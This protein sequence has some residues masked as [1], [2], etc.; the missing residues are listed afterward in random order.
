MLSEHEQERFLRL[1]A[2]AQPA[3][4]A[5]IHAVVRD[6][7]AAKDV[8]QETALVLFRRFADYDSERPFLAWALGVA[9]L[10]VLG[11]HRDEA[12]NLVICDSELLDSFTEAWAEQAPATSEQSGAL[13]ICLERMAA[14]P[15]QILRWRYFEDLKSEEISRRLGSKS[16]AVRVT[17]QRLREQLRACVEKQMRQERRAW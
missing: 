14:R 12:R 8:L 4:A 3:V 13:E 15:R 1:W 5:F 10:Q 16:A 2:D 9:K 6:S 7:A 11:F 17:L